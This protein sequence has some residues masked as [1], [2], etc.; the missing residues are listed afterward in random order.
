MDKDRIYDNMNF[1][2]MIKIF[3]SKYSKDEKINWPIGW[4]CKIVNLKPLR[5][6][7]L[8]LKSGFKSAGKNKVIF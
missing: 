5:K 1:H 4:H 8:D 2:E 3:S 7:S 6:K